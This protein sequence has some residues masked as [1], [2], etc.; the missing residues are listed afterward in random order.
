MNR[1]LIMSI[2]L[3]SLI[4]VSSSAMADGKGVANRGNSAAAR[5]D[6]T[7]VSDPNCLSDFVVALSVDPDNLFTGEVLTRMITDGFF[8]AGIVPDCIPLV[9]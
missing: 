7:T 8:L 3:V 9:L 1:S 6:H 5:A 4:A 2:A